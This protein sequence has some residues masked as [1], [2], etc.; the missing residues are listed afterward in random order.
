MAFPYTNPYSRS[1]P[2]QQTIDSLIDCLERQQDVAQNLRAICKVEDESWSI[3]QVL[4]WTEWVAARKH[5]D[6]VDDENVIIA[7]YSSLHFLVSERWDDSKLLLVYA[8]MTFQGNRSQASLLQS[9]Y[10]SIVACKEN[11]A[12]QMTT[13]CA[14][15]AVWKQLDRLQ[16]HCTAGSYSFTS[17]D[18]VWWMM[19]P[20]Y[21]S[22]S[23]T[24]EAS[25]RKDE[26]TYL[27]VPNT[28]VSLALQG[29]KMTQE[30]F[31]SINTTTVSLCEFKCTCAFLLKHLLQHGNVDWLFHNRSNIDCLRDLLKEA[32]RLNDLDMPAS[33]Y[34]KYSLTCLEL[35]TYLQLHEH[36][37]E[38]KR[39]LQTTSIVAHMAMAAFST[40]ASSSQADG[41]RWSQQPSRE[42]QWQCLETV[43]AISRVSPSN[44]TIGLCQHSSTRSFLEAAWKC[45]FDQ[46]TDLSPVILE[47][48]IFLH[49]SCRVL[50]RESLKVAIAQYDDDV[51]QKLLVKLLEEA[52]RDHSL[53]SA[54][55]LKLLLLDRLD[56][57]R[58]D[59]L[60]RALWDSMTSFPT[61][62]FEALIELAASN[63]SFL[64]FYRPLLLSLVDVSCILLLADLPMQKTAGVLPA[65]NAQAVETLVEILTPSRMRVDV[66]KAHNIANETLTTSIIESDEGTPPIHNL[67]RLDTSISLFTPD[68]ERASRGL[69]PAIRMATAT[70]LALLG[71]GRTGAHDNRTVL[72]RGRML[73][74]ANSFVAEMKLSDVSQNDAA[75]CLDWTRRRLRLLSALGV[76]D[77][78]EHL[79]V[80]VHCA[81]TEHLSRMTHSRRI[82]ARME[83]MLND[84]AEKEKRLIIEKDALRARLNSQAVSNNHEKN[85]IQINGARRAKELVEVHTIEREKA[86]RRTHEFVHRLSEEQQNVEK[87]QRSEAEARKSLQASEA[88][89]SKLTAFH[90]DLQQRADRYT[91]EFHKAEAELKACK[92]SL[93]EAVVT[94]KRLLEQ[95]AEQRDHA[96]DAE[97][98]EA[99]MRDSLESL[100]GDMVALA[101]LYEI[102]EKEFT[103]SR[104]RE[105]KELKELRE[106][107]LDERQRCRN[108]EESQKSIEYENEILQNK[109]NKAKEKLEREREERKREAIQRQKRSGSGAT[110]YINQI[111]NTSASDRGKSRSDRD[112]SRKGLLGGDGKENGTRSSLSSFRS[113]SNYEDRRKL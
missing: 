75:S 92:V 64:D 57:V 2:S 10:E 52:R 4:R 28:V 96:V 72:L 38:F 55:L 100:F 104:A 44:V 21:G 46:F 84:S 24:S 107:L 89:L 91:S 23:S 88:E 66:C 71:N 12:V 49:S 61:K 17:E 36:A 1:S 97:E 65:F 18:T 63:S 103:S 15:A 70:L 11:V 67:S 39:F 93:N 54:S 68:E 30:V 110:S 32:G 8:A 5:S 29:L 78:E 31:Q 113:N 47:G 62:C 101:S 83:M 56:A 53:Q 9:L 94:E 82:V 76:P 99:Q 48:L 90:I 77:N 35:L 25:M 73:D 108:L 14:I 13:L 58:H 79:A 3:Q 43:R 51:F 42:L 27:D 37:D 85:E 33:Q 7:V 86:E 19:H 45:I 26:D 50:S 34:T 22:S 16:T 20:L 102:K 69:D 109:Y 40:S 80:L 106:R 59:E 95:I 6:G 60:S 74:A 41:P 105:E 111:H 98:A 81:D 87:L 112:P